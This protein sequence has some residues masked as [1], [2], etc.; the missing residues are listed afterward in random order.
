MGS[1]RVVTVLAVGV[2]LITSVLPTMVHADDNY[3]WCLSVDGRSGGKVY[4]SDPFSAPISDNLKAETAF[5]NYVRSHYEVGTDVRSACKNISS[6]SEAR[7][8]RDRDAGMKK[9]TEVVFTTW[10]Y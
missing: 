1:I 10:T 7:S 8:S 4:Y 5:E 3:M 9:R 6:M 2:F